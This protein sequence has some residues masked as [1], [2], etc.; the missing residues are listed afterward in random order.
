MAAAIWLT[1]LPA[2]AASL[3]PMVQLSGS[4]VRLSDLFDDAGPLASR[5]LGPGPA[6]GARIVVEAPQLAA[7]AR[8]FR[9]KWDAAPGAR[10]ILE[11]PGR[12]LPREAVLSALG[13]ALT[14][15]GAPSDV[16]LEL[17]TYDPPVVALDP[18]IS[19]KVEQLD[20]DAASGRFAADMAAS[21]TAMD[22]VRMRVTGRVLEMAE[23]P[24]PVRR[25]E[26]GNPIVAS[27]LQVA[28]VRASSGAPMFRDAQDAIG[29]AP[30][31]ALPAGQPIPRSDLVVVPLVHKG[32]LVRLELASPGLV[33]TALG[34]AEES[35]PAGVQVRI[36]N[37]A[38]GALLQAMVTGPDEGRVLPGSLPLKRGIR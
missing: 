22:P 33:L 6:P 25:L 38:S 8:Q 14:G 4:Q 28:H 31:Q 36:R 19:V 2:A 5:V 24:V 26:A 11:R 37:P 16:E 30:R 32:D 7:I 9:V 18:D 12:P 29:L 21:S 15:A 13:V 34:I 17:P 20:Y 27:D 1:A 10:A 23:L 35:A 3:R